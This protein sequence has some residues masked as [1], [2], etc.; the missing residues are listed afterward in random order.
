MCCVTPSKLLPLW[1][2]SVCATS[3]RCSGG[4][5]NLAE[6]PWL[7]RMR[8]PSFHQVSAGARPSG[9]TQCPLADSHLNL[10][11]GSTVSPGS[12][13]LK[14][15]RLPPPAQAPGFAEMSLAPN[16]PPEQAGALACPTGC[17]ADPGALSKCWQEDAGR[18]RKEEMRTEI[19]CFQSGK[20][21]LQM[22][23]AS[24]PLVGLDA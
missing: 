11:P 5:L 15:R 20:H 12:Q 17:L 6:A 13:H 18:G 24:D 19:Q 3:R 8:I 21:F 22:L 1:P 2:G 9:I 14:V 16:R 4:D 23:A 7:K 10:P